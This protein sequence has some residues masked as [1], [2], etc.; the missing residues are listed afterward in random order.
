MMPREKDKPEKRQRRR[1]RSDKGKG[2]E[3]EGDQEDGGDEWERD[4]PKPENDDRF[5]FSHEGRARME[6]NPFK[7]LHDAAS[8]TRHHDQETSRRKGSLSQCGAD[9]VNGVE[10]AK[11]HLQE[12]ASLE[13]SH[14]IRKSINQ[15]VI[16][17]KNVQIMKDMKR[18]S[19][20]TA[21]SNTA[22]VKGR[23]RTITSL[24]HLQ[25]QGN[26]NS[27]GKPC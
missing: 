25:L 8:E 27:T 16:D 15:D 14:A 24:L 12:N 1:L 26:P 2:K 20:T 4:E 21:T 22:V 6:A 3:K 5:V 11:I 13:G 7:D 17:Q 10:T 23:T 19:S 18:V 9:L